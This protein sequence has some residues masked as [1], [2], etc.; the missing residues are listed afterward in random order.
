ML[1]PFPG[2][3][4]AADSISLATAGAA[5]RWH[6]RDYLL[7]LLL[8][9]LAFVS[10]FHNLEY[11]NSAVYDETHIGRFVNGYRCGSCLLALWPYAC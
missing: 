1:K 4:E 6:R 3:L 5:S 9:V 11:P 2:R 7:L 10:R 8:T